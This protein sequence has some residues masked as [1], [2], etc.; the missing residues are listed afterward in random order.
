MSKVKKSGWEMVAW[1]Y[2]EAGVISGGYFWMWCSHPTPLRVGRL[3]GREA[4]LRA[5]SLRCHHFCS[6]GTQGAAGQYEVPWPHCLAKRKSGCMLASSN[7]WKLIGLFYA[8]APMS[9]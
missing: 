6:V 2:L 8:Q 5:A 4:Q 9:G 3:S 7:D 1:L